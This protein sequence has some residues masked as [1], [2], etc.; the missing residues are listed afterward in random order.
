MYHLSASSIATLKNCPQA[1]RLKYREGLRPIEDTESQRVGTNW[2]TLHEIYASAL[3]GNWQKISDQSIGGSKGS[4]WIGEYCTSERALECVIEHLN[5]QYAGKPANKTKQEWMLERQILLTSFIGYLWYYQNDL[6]EVL[7][8]EI[9]FELPLRV[10]NLNCYLP[11]TEVMRV[12]KIDHI[13]KWKNMI[14][15]MERKSTVRS[16]ASDSD[17]WDKS[18]KDTQISMYALAFHDSVELEG[19]D[20]YSAFGIEFSEASRIGGATIGTTLYDV[21]HRPT[22]KPAMLTQKDT[23]EFIRTGEYF[24]QKFEVNVAD[25]S[26]WVNKSDVCETEQG[27]KGFAIRETVEMF[28]AR[29]LADIQSRSDFYFQRREIV[30]TDDELKRFESELYNIYQAMKM[31]EKNKCWF[32]NENHCRATYRCEY[33]PI[34]Y[35][36]R[37]ATVCD[38]KTTPDGFK[39]RLVDMKQNE[40]VADE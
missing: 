29:L 36:C 6:I 16:I 27:K 28:G 4:Q 14:G 25:N 17:Y 8:S 18:Q 20:I 35:G 2:H 32:E 23:A 1:F 38:D 37:A 34:C 11:T 24:G 26:V 15:T 9:P 22:I 30:R 21:W 40:V 12:G 5:K 31:F 19:N 3:A 39:R 10:P 33:I 7:A 13:V